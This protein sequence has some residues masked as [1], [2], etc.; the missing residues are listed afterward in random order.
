VVV[1]ADDHQ[2]LAVLRQQQRAQ[3]LVVGLEHQRLGLARGAAANMPAAASASSIGGVAARVS[4]GVMQVL[5]RRAR[6][7]VAD[8][9]VLAGPGAKVVPWQRALQKGR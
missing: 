6:F 7:W 8:T 5:L 9:V 1:L 2:V 3:G 4:S